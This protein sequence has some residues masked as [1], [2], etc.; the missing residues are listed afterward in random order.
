MISNYSKIAC[1]DGNVIKSLNG[2]IHKDSAL[3][4]DG[5]V[6][7]VVIIPYGVVHQKS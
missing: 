3:G 4:Y 5:L 6:P 2:E 1:S 7:E